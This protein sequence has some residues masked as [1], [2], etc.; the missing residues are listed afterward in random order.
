MELKVKE[1]KVKNLTDEIIELDIT[2]D[3]FR[4][5]YNDDMASKDKALQKRDKT[6]MDMKLEC[7][8][9]LAKNDD[10]TI[11]SPRTT[12]TTSTDTIRPASSLILAICV[13]AVSWSNSIVL[14]S[15]IFSLVCTNSFCILIA[16]SS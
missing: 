14:S 9:L 1:A 6:I 5:E 3:E 10:H 2:M 8:I 4:I 11:S 13:L 12:D 7:M 16:S 15:I